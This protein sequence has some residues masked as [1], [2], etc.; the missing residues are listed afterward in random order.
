MLYPSYKTEARCQGVIGSSVSRNDVSSLQNPPSGN[1][2][3]RTVPLC[4]ANW[5]ALRLGIA[6][7]RKLGKRFRRFESCLYPPSSESRT[8]HGQFMVEILLRL[9]NVHAESSKTITGRYIN[10]KTKNDPLSDASRAKQNILLNL[11][12]ILSRQSFVWGYRFFDNNILLILS[13][14]Y[15]SPLPARRAAPRRH[16]FPLTF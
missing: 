5:A 12:S 10:I 8:T 13:Y 4:T 3:N 11:R 7:R 14:F 15:S 1:G 9:S 16:V 2:S 6:I